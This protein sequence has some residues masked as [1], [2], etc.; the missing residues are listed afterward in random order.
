MALKQIVATLMGTYLPEAE[1]MPVCIKF[2]GETPSVGRSPESAPDSKN[3]H[4]HNHLVTSF[5]LHLQVISTGVK[6]ITTIDADMFNT[7][8]APAPT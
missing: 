1:A 4:C 8:S 6:I 3:F 7:S 2:F 5:S